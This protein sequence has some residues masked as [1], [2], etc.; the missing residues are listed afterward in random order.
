MKNTRKNISIVSL[1]IVLLIA[2]INTH[3][4]T[5]PPP[6]P[7]GHGESGD[8]PGG[9]APLA[10]GLVILMALGGAYVGKKIY[11]IK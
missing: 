1:L 4:Q 2:T 11:D 8:V 7:G 3:A 9:G 6:P 5:D 10:S